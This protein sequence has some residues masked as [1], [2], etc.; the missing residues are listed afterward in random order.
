MGAVTAD[1]GA[2]REGE[3]VGAVT[4]DVGVRHVLGLGVVCISHEL[5]IER[6]WKLPLPQFHI[7]W[8]Q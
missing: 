7:A 6:H 8:F 4:A 5:R 1:V 2:P 3:H